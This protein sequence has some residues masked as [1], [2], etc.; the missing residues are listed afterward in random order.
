VVCGTRFLLSA[1]SG[2]HPLYKQRLLDAGDTVVT[3]L[4]GFGWPAPHRVVQNDATRRWL[5]GGP[6]GPRLLRAFQRVS[7]PVF[8]RSPMQLQMRLA[9]TQ[10]ASRPLFGPAAA[11]AGGAETLVDAGP[12]Y[13]GACV[14][15]IAEIRPAAELVRELSPG[16]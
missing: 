13:A 7:A 10:R 6:R 4:F 12:L 14:E 15:R 11:T 1:E 3:E 5:R 16:S 9:A 8:A 2:A